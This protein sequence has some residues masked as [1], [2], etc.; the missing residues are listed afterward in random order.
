[1]LHLAIFSKGVISKILLGQ[2]T[3]DARISKIKCPPFE[4][5]SRDDL[6]LM[7][8]SGGRIL[9]FFIVGKVQFI[10]NSSGDKISSLIK[11]HKNELSMPEDFLEKR[12]NANYLTLLKIKKPTKLKVPVKVSKK[13]LSGWV[14]LGNESS[15]QIRFF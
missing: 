4:N 7:K 5:I 6:V 8:K 3:L 11:K 1:M 15:S 10:E 2:K 12:R 13:S 14:T 9:G